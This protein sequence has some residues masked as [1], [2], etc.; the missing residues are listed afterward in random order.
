M[1]NT[2]SYRFETWLLEWHFSSITTVSMVIILLMYPW[3]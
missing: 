1:I 3:Y 2:E